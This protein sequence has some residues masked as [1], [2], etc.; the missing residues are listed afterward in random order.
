MRHS[1]AEKHLTLPLRGPHPALARHPLPQAGEGF[2]G[3][4]SAPMGKTYAF[5]KHPVGTPARQQ[6]RPAV[7]PSPLLPGQPPEKEGRGG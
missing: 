6:Q 1:P 7:P 3:A 4:R 2:V 5:P